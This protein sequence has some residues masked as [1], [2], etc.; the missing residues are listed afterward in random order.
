MC[1]SDVAGQ[2]LPL[3]G[4]D[5]TQNGVVSDIGWICR[6]HAAKVTYI[7]PQVELFNAIQRNGYRI[8]YL[9]ARAIGQVKEIHIS[10][11]TFASWG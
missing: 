4:K 3:F 5:W 8:V 7:M 11:C 1:R 2:V 6:T 10:T 9:S